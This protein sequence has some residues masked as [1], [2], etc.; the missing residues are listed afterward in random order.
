MFN[1]KKLKEKI[2]YSQFVRG[3]LLRKM[4]V[5]MVLLSVIPLM[6]G[7]VLFVLAGENLIRKDVEN[8]NLKTAEN[9]AV[10]IDSHIQN[11]ES[12]ISI[13]TKTKGFLAGDKERQEWMLEALFK[14]IPSLSKITLVETTGKEII[15][16]SRYHYFTESD[17]QNVSSKEAFRVALGGENYLGD[18]YVVQTEPYFEIAAPVMSQE[19]IKWVILG[20]LNLKHF[21]DLISG[22]EVGEK[23]I[24]YLTDKKGRIIAHPDLSLVFAEKVSQCPNLRV[25]NSGTRSAPAIYKDISGVEVLGTCA[26][27]KRLGWHVVVEQPISEVYYNLNQMKGFVFL[28]LIAAA[29][30]AIFFGVYYIRKIIRPIELLQADVGKIAL[31]NFNS[32]VEIKTGDELEELAKNFN[33]MAENLKKSYEHLQDSESQL[34]KKIEEKTKELS[35]TTNVLKQKANEMS[36]LL[37]VLK[38]A[39][40]TL[41]LSELFPVVLQKIVSLFGVQAA[42]VLLIDETSLVRCAEV[43]KCEET[44]CPAFSSENLKCWTV[45]HTLCRKEIQGTFAKKIE[46]CVK[47]IVFKNTR[48]KLEAVVGVNMPTG[49]CVIAEEFVCRRALSEL[50]PIIFSHEELIGGKDKNIFADYIKVKSQIAIPLI[51]WT[52]GDIVGVLTLVSPNDRF[53]TSSEITLLSSMADYLALAIKRIHLYEAIRRSAVESRSLYEIS[54]ALGSTLD[55]K[56]LLDLVVHFAIGVVHGDV[57]SIMLLDEEKEELIIK[58]SI[59]LTESVVKKTRVK[60][61]ESIAGWVAKTGEALWISDVS[62]DERFKDLKPREKLAAAICVPLIVKEKILGVLSVGSYYPQRFLESDLRMISTLA[63]QAAVAVNNAQLFSR[64]EELYFLTVK[65]FVAAIEAK[66]PYTRGHSE[67]VTRNAVAIAREINL[68]DEE[69][70]LI[71]TAGL[72]HDIGKIGV[73]EE[74][75]NKPSGLTTEEY[76]MVK[77]HPLIATK[78]VEE[79]P[80]LRKIVPLI[81]H[82]HERYD[83]NGYV[84]GLKGETIPL[85]AR[86]LAVADAFDAMTSVRPYRAAKS[87]EKAISELKKNSKTQFDPKIV[88]VFCKLLEEE[89]MRKS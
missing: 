79:I 51:D 17:L 84:N 44:K 86:I 43:H 34:E 2:T 11:I 13:A 5:L 48:L 66:D 82:H 12:L 33:L 19:K 27:I 39:S 68:S 28:L 25:S 71:E 21:W 72:L 7:G 75:L 49:I 40:S 4:V 76:D 22:F 6:V 50:K 29:L 18:V 77:L 1:F 9:A 42:G 63:G 20:E 46:A 70:K 37:D 45:P 24:V 15:K 58:A 55:V 59:G 8:L 80:T 67:R 64:L 88:E 41:E 69:V 65:A 53:Y 16:L 81:A 54:R 83:G 10:E 35:K 78:I 3:K 32:R 30:T 23:G 38:T 57:A 87:L 62:K 31:G 89:E 73:K 61:G 47:C 56:A 26:E 60:V 85:G 74:I 14:G 36:I 52:W